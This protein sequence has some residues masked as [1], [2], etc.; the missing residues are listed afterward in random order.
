MIT[1]K[2]LNFE[3]HR[4]GYFGNKLKTW[5]SFKEFLNDNYNEPVSIRYSGSNPGMYVVYNC[6]N[7]I[8]TIKEFISTGANENLF[9]INE[10]AP[11]ERL[12][13][14]GE[15]MK[16]YNGYYLF[17]SLEKGKMRDCLKN[18]IHLSGL[19]VKLLLQQ[20]LFPSSFDDIMDLLDLYPNH[21]IEFSAYELPL[22]DCQNR[23]TIIWEVRLY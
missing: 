22:G 14:Q 10:S 8:Q 18:G 2:H 1:T 13:I 19:S 15:L 21:V 3:Y 11:D 5:Y 7:P 16:D 9:I 20:Y 6:T 23:N 12:L 4:K 17:Y